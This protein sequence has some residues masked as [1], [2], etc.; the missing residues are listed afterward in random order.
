VGLW[1]LVLRRLEFLSDRVLALLAILGPGICIDSWRL[2]LVEG[3]SGLQQGE[4]SRA[5]SGALNLVNVFG[6]WISMDLRGGDAAQYWLARG[7]PSP[8]PSTCVY[9]SLCHGLLVAEPIMSAFEAILRNPCRRRA[10]GRTAAA[11]PRDQSCKAGRV[12]GQVCR[13]KQS[14][15][16]LPES[17]IGQE[18]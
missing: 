6:V 5:H 11:H 13:R 4:Q 16:Q 14:S 15:Q 17:Q 9:S 10:P 3:I 18:R 1:L 2:V 7:P 12:V 8:P